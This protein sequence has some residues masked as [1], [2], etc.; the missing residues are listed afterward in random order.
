MSPEDAFDLLLD[1]VAF[2]YWLAAEGISYREGRQRLSA[3]ASSATT[4][5]SRTLRQ[6]R[7]AHERRGKMCS[8][9]T[10]VEEL[11]DFVET[12]GRLP[13]RLRDVFQLCF[14]DGLTRREAA[15]RLGISIETVR[16]HLRRLRQL[17]RATSAARGATR[18]R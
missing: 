11:C 9:R 5:E 10:D 12:A 1:Q 4:D 15:Q 14:V 2:T 16:A 6:A 8:G 3:L 18:G 17:R 13:P 7:A